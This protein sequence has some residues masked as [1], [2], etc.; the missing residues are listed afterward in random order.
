MNNVSFDFESLLT[1]SAGIRRHPCPGRVPGVR[2][3]IYGRQRSAV[4]GPLA[5][6]HSSEVILDFLPAWGP[7]FPG[8]LRGPR[9]RLGEEFFQEFEQEHIDGYIW[10][11]HA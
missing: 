3:A 8:V 6:M 5:R 10:E 1:E 7:R 2:M 9:V 11:A 4:H